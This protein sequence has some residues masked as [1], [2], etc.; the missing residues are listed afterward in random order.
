MILYQFEKNTIYGINLVFDL[1]K[2]LVRKRFP[3]PPSPF[4]SEF[5]K[6]I[7]VENMECYI[8]FLPEYEQL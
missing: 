4:V 6:R 5:S 1:V 2:Q 8:I 7:M 3:A